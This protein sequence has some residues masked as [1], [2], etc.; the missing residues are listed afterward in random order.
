MNKLI[1]QQPIS[2]HYVPQFYL[3]QFSTKKGKEYSIFTFDKTLKKIFIS[4]IKNVCC[5][6]YFYDFMDKIPYSYYEKYPVN[7]SKSGK[8]LKKINNIKDLAELK[9]NEEPIFCASPETFL[10]RVETE[11]SK[12]Y[13]RILELED[14]TELNNYEKAATAMFVLFQWKRTRAQ[15]EFIKG[16][17]RN[18]AIEQIGKTNSV[19]YIR[20]LVSLC[21]L[22]IPPR[23]FHLNIIFNIDN[24]LDIFL[25]SGWTLYVNKTSLPYWT[26]DNPVAIENTTSI[27]PCKP[28]LI[29]E[30]CKIYFPLSPKICLLIYDTCFYK[31][32]PKILDTD[33]QSV[34]EKNKL[35]FEKSMR[36]VF[37]INDISLANELINK[38]PF[39]SNS[40]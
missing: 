31:F 25:R 26:S 38:T 23:Y 16:L 29:R 35:Q 30:G 3:R 27:D 13:K 20:F 40:H 4:N 39:V 22:D 15:R 1:N 8:K 7:E 28:H 17:I 12:A 14:L 37:S 10:N 2:H 11:F 6:D 34:I 33:I 19:E 5:E 32:P 21:Y 24:E 9:D 18:F 36:Q